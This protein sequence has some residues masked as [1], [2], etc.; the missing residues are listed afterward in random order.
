MG[1]RA[2]P[3]TL[4]GRGRDKG[5]ARLGEENKAMRW[6]YPNSVR[7]DRNFLAAVGLGTV[8]Q[9]FPRAAFPL[10]QH[11]RDCPGSRIERKDIS[12]ASSVRI[13]AAEGAAE[14]PNLRILPIGNLHFVAIGAQP[15]DV[16]EPARPFFDASI[17]CAT[18]QIR[19][20]ATQQDHASHKRLKNLVFAPEI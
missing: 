6:K 20:A 12:K 14:A 9:P 2:F 10:G 19:M 16:F 15:G 4:G 5:R 8:E 17:E 11:K 13:S 18:A 7:R 3:A 1:L